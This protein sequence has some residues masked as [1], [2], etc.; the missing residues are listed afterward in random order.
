MAENLN[1]D[2]IAKIDI[3]NHPEYKTLACKYED[4]N[5]IGV[6]FDNL[7]EHIHKVHVSQERENPPANGVR[8]SRLNFVIFSQKCYI[9]LLFPI[10]NNST[11]LY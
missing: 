6:D 8:V 5:F 1:R 2:F 3:K 11:D 4:C 7:V 9:S 10:R